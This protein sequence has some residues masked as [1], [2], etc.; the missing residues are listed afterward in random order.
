MAYFGLSAGG[1]VMR[2]CF[3]EGVLENEMEKKA[4]LGD[5]AE[6]TVGDFSGFKLI[7]H[8]PTLCAARSPVEDMIA[9]T[10]AAR[11]RKCVVHAPRTGRGRGRGRS[12]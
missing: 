8:K 6:R 10:G 5:Q 2:V 7:R 4:D 12:R 9:S 1:R 11:H 3:R